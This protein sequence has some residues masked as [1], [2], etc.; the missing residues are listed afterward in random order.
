MKTRSMVLALAAAA[1]VPLLA[2]VSSVPVTPAINDER[3]AGQWLTYSG[4]PQAHRFSPL[5]QITVNNVARLRPTWVYQPPG[6]GPLEGTPIVADGAMYVTSGPATV[7][8]LNMQ[9]RQA[10]SGSGRGRL[11]RACSTSGFPRVNRGVAILDDTV[12]VGT[13]DGYLVALDAHIGHRTLDRSRR[14]QHDRPFDH[15]RA[16]RRRRQD[17]RRHQR[18][19]SRHPR[20]PRRLRREDRQAA[21][22]ILDRSRTG[23][24]GQRHL[25]R[26]QLEARRRRDL[27]DRL[28]RSGS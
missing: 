1:G 10:R 14:R 21:L 24:A 3:T 15:R 2:Q 11:Q 18:R 27:A 23:R 26:R 20:F 5:A 8:A 22:A 4:T 17:H 25:A 13:L 19:R 28:V 9:E 6:T 12:Y 16:A 7:V